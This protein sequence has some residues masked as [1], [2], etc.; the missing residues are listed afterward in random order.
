MIK[1][2]ALKRSFLSLF[3]CL[4]QL[5]YKDQIS[6]ENRGVESEDKLLLDPSY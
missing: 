4:E 2:F 6:S 1:N 3:T 5:V